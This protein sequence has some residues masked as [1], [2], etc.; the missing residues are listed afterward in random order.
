MLLSICLLTFPLLYSPQGAIGWNF[1]K[2]LINQFH[3]TR[4]SIISKILVCYVPKKDVKLI[5]MF[6]IE[7]LG[8]NDININSKFICWLLCTL[9]KVLNTLH[10]LTDQMTHRLKWSCC[11][12]SVF[13]KHFY[14]KETLSHIF[15]FSLLH[16][17]QRSSLLPYTDFSLNFFKS[18]WH[19]I[20]KMLNPMPAILQVLRIVT[21]PLIKIWEWGTGVDG[22]LSSW[23]YTL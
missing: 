12:F 23:Y 7:K 18:E 8:W 14:F 16:D 5:E 6:K 17:V 10:A 11:S 15:H 4:K 20:H 19:N 22:T 9:N 3:I 2:K 1:K 21:I 13:K